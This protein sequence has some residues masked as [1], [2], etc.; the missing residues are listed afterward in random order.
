MLA[1]C[2]HFNRSWAADIRHINQSDHVN[3]RPESGSFLA[4]YLFSLS[5]IDYPDT[6]DSL[7][8]TFAFAVAIGGKADMPL[9]GAYVG[10]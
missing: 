6:G 8:L 7:A 9:C 4:G 2:E 1:I 10:F 3:I 5:S